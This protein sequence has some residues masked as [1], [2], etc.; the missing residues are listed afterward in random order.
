[1]HLIIML[2]EV[3]N[4]PFVPRIKERLKILE[5]HCC[6]TCLRSRTRSRWSFGHGFSALQRKELHSG[7]HK[8]M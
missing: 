4:H 6:H 2:T 1:M 3:V 8:A 7:I 5:G